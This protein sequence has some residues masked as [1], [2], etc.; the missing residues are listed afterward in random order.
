MGW[1]R[2]YVSA[3][4]GIIVF[5]LVYELVAFLD[6]RDSTPPLTNVIVAET[7]WMVTMPFLVWLVVHFGSRYLGRPIL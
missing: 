1:D 2:V 3:W 5:A 6:G 4:Y 7:S